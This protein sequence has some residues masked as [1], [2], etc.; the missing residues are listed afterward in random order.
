[1]PF[2]RHG[3]TVSSR[4]SRA[5][6]RATRS[7]SPGVGRSRRRRGISQSRRSD[8]AYPTSAPAK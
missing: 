3:L 5:S 8:R 6:T 7:A 1:V 2:G 4:A